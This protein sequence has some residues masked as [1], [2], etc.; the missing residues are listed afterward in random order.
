[1]K[2]LE[3]VIKQN[4]ANQNLVA[5]DLKKINRQGKYFITH[6]E[7][8]PSILERVILS[9]ANVKD[10]EIKPTNIKDKAFP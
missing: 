7:N 2:S 4:K 3:Q 9:P 6:I 8:L 10:A 5:E 1:M